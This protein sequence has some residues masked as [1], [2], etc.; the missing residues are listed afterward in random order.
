[1]PFRSGNPWRF[2]PGRSGN[3]DGVS[4]ER[5]P[6]NGAVFAVDGLRQLSSPVKV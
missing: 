1:M 6:Q 3:P 4:K 2:T 5:L